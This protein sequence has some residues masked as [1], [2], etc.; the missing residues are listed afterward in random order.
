[1]YGIKETEMMAG[2]LVSIDRDDCISCGN[3]W[4]DCPEVFRESPDDGRSELLPTYRT[5]DD[6]GKGSVP[7][8]LKDCAVR[9]ETGCP[10]GIIHI[11]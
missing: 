2:A 10:V 9:A 6:P 4:T 11:A 7:G 1:M 8:N 5:G 3:C